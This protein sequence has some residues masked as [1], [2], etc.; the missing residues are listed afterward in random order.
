MSAQLETVTG[1]R[2][3]MRYSVDPALIGGA[4]ARIGSTVYDGSVRGQLAKMGRLLGSA[5]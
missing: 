2:L 5:Q 3:R 4:I 1:K